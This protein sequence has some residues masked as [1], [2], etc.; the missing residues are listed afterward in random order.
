MDFYHGQ[1]REAVQNRYLETEPKRVIAHRTLATYFRE[2]LD[3]NGDESWSG[4]YRRSFGELP[5]QLAHAGEADRLFNLLSDFTFLEKKAA[6]GIVLGSRLPVALSADGI[7]DLLADFD[8]YLA[9]RQMPALGA[10]AEDADRVNCIRSLRQFVRDRSHVLAL[11]PDSLLQDCHNL[12]EQG[13]IARIAQT[14]L[15]RHGRHHH[16]WVRRLNRPT[17]LP[18][19]ATRLLGHESPIEGV[20]FTSDGRFVIS[21][22]GCEPVR[23]WEAESNRVMRT[24]DTWE[25]LIEHLKH[26]EALRDPSRPEHSRNLK[27]VLSHVLTEHEMQE[28][29]GVLD[30][31]AM[32][33]K[34]SAGGGAGFQYRGGANRDIAVVEDVA[35]ILIDRSTLC[36]MSGPEWRPK[37]RQINAD[38][39]L[40][41]LTASQ[42]SFFI[43]DGGRVL[44]FNKGGDRLS[45]LELEHF[46]PE[47]FAVSMDGATLALVAGTGKLDVLRRT[48]ETWKPVSSAFLQR[49]DELWQL[50]PRPSR[51][52]QDR[53]ELQF[54]H[55]SLALD[56]EGRKLCCAMSFHDWSGEVCLFDLV[57][58]ECSRRFPHGDGP[59]R[60]S[61]DG[62]EIVVTGDWVGPW[63]LVGVHGSQESTSRFL[64]L[65]ASNALNHLAYSPDGSRLAV[66]CADGT[67]SVVATGDATQLNSMPLPVSP[68]RDNIIG[69]IVSPDRRIV[70]C[71]SYDHFAAGYAL[72]DGH[73]VFATTQ[74][75]GDA[76]S[77]IVEIG[78]SASGE[79]LYVNQG[80]NDDSCVRIWR[81]VLSGLKSVSETH[82]QHGCELGCSFS[83]DGNEAAIVRVGQC[84]VIELASETIVRETQLVNPTNHGFG[85]PEVRM[86]LEGD[87]FIKFE[88]FDE[89]YV[90]LWKSVG[91]IERLDGDVSLPP[92][93]S[94][95]DLKSQTDK[96]A[97]RQRLHP[98]SQR[99]FI[100]EI[101]ET[102]N[103]GEQRAVARYAAGG[104]I[105]FLGVVPGSNRFVIGD[106]TGDIAVCALETFEPT[107]RLEPTRS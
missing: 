86:N 17:L 90:F 91:G 88:Y 100:A 29:G 80:F 19:P 72:E 105:S 59:V 52:A 10:D 69:G 33:A 65:Q 68:C 83:P 1:F 48:G 40:G 15:A 85:A 25:P 55:F 49:V 84:V 92:G 12:A 63:K 102:E 54:M 43:V 89:K 31:R 78:L 60:F 79:Y 39:G 11:L 46:L 99:G 73:Q 22:A 21:T 57:T 93:T 66:G 56:P 23:V 27:E 24:V 41:P 62:R 42:G 77:R 74:L 53:R 58:L 76:S 44:E 14:W 106:Q 95:D 8:L 67:I 13:P 51:S 34:P 94:G 50:G 37:M 82:A 47:A 104:E 9:G 81:I 26:L 71:W 75:G 5:F 4:E 107:E 61:P 35:A 28:V 38:G 20:R 103:S 16:S 64:A 70:A 36:L 6:S 45:A 98:G 97:I 96:F 18:P 7:Y 30:S 32:S 101:W 2:K 3:P 87:V